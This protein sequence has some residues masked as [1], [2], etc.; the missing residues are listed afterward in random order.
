MTKK[1]RT[2]S[3]H[4]HW[5]GGVTTSEFWPPFCTAQKHACVWQG[6][7]LR[8][9]MVSTLF[10]SVAHCD[11]A[12]RMVYMLNLGVTYVAMS[13]V[14][15]S[16][17]ATRQTCCV[18]HVRV[19]WLWRFFRERTQAKHSQTNMGVPINEDTIE[20]FPVKNKHV[21]MQGM[22]IVYGHSHVLWEPDLQLQSLSAATG[23]AADPETWDSTNQ[24]SSVQFVGISYPQPQIHTMFNHGIGGRALSHAM[25]KGN[26]EATRLE[27]TFGS[28]TST[29]SSQPSAVA[30]KTTRN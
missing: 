26:K 11:C 28:P 23:K 29:C 13:S 12:A 22:P 20:D 19:S 14:S 6:N 21:W 9:R 25:E 18:S 24:V 7:A 16:Q 17:F 5:L 15:E 8:I 4:V 2:I 27:Q 3:N 10:S 1:R 30:Q